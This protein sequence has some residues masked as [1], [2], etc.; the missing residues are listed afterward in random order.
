MSPQHTDTSRVQSS[1]RMQSSIVHKLLTLLTIISEAK[2]PMTFSE[3]VDKTGMN[4]ST[5]HRLLAIGIEERMIRHDSQSKTYLLGARV[6]DL[7]RHAYNGFDLQAMAMDEMV[8]LF[9]LCDVNVTIAV[10]S[11]H[12]IVYLR[13]LESHRSMGG[14]Q[15][16]GMRDPIHCSASGKAIA[17][18]V[19]EGVL[20]SMLK[21]YDFVRYTDRTLPSFDAFKK[22]LVEVRKTGIGWNDRED[23][24]FFLGISAPVFN[25]VSEPI[26]ALNMWSTHPRHTL[27]D[28]KVWSEELKA[29]A[30]RVTDKIGGMPP[31]G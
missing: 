2:K 13:I 10:L 31:K 14:I 16:P 20:R 3:I 18:F 9:E 28:V 21:D 17:A 6:F 22:E 27:D 26:A 1:Y 25:Y 11:E 23:N 8:R 5:I 30:A 19:P 7:V 12:E 4:K 29:A 15:R 24:E